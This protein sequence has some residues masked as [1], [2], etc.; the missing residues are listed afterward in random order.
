[1]GDDSAVEPAAKSAGAARAGR[2]GGLFG[3]FARGGDKKSQGATKTSDESTAGDEPMEKQSQIGYRARSGEMDINSFRRS[4]RNFMDSL[5]FEFF[6]IFLVLVYAIIIFIDLAV[7]NSTS[8]DGN[9]SSTESD[10]VREVFRTFDLIFLPIFMVE[11]VFRLIGEGMAFL[12]V[13]INAIDA[14]VVVV[15]LVVVLLEDTC[16]GCRVLQLLRIIRL[17]RFAVIIGK[18][19]RSRENAKM[20]RKVRLPSSRLHM[21]RPRCGGGTATCCAG[22]GRPRAAEQPHATR[23]RLHSLPILRL[24]PPS[25]RGAAACDVPSARRTCREGARIPHRLFEPSGLESGPGERALDDGGD[26]RRPALRRRRFRRRHAEEF[27]GGAA[28]PSPLTPHLS[29]L[30]PAPTHMLVPL[31]TDAAL[32]HHALLS[33]RER[34]P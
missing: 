9:A 13:A 7:D 30:G 6:I 34:V 23:T 15:S 16:K 24:T 10:S 12:H 14:V 19:Q 20:R 22:R 25:S 11:L 29:S 18:L 2:K 27:A 28:Y 3:G 5:R 21:R 4:V 31:T 33:W 26:R 32:L 1:M 17:F 8:E